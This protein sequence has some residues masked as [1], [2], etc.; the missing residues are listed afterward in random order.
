MG[1]VRTK[2]ARKE[3]STANSALA[4]PSKFEQRRPKK[5]SQDANGTLGIQKIKS[6]LRQTRRLL[7]KD[8]LTP[9]VRVET[10]RRL[11]A[12]EGDLSAAEVG[13][14]ERTLAVRYHSVKF[15]ERQ[16]VSRKLD[17]TKKKLSESDTPELRSALHDLR[18][19]LNYTMH[20]PKM[21]KYI[22]LF[23]P[24]LRN[25]E[26]QEPA[27]DSGREE[28]RAWIRS[29]MQSSEL[30]SEPELHLDW[31]KDSGVA[32]AKWGGEK[33]ASKKSQPTKESEPQEDPEDEFFEDDD[34]E[35]SSEES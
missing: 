1:P 8:N 30:P 28:I 6:A 25:G 10:E 12:L 3:S 11:K 27:L 35:E 21:K 4:G 18:V 5:Q 15:F 32:D 33:K 7:S 9:D 31:K 20:Y 14:K 29:Q 2:Q 22:S 23:P 16:K 19:D 34:G 26:T 13:K 17:Q 24:E